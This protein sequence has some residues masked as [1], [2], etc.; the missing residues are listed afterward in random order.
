[1]ICIKIDELTPCLKD[2]LTGE[3]LETEVIRIKR[4]SFLKKFNKKNGWYISWSDEVDK[5]EVYALVLKGTVDIQGLVSIREEKSYRGV[6][7]SWAVAAPHNNIELADEPK[8]SGVGGHLIAI[9]IERS[10]QLGYGG[11]TTGFCK[12]ISTMEHFIKKYNAKS[13]GLIH[14]YQIGFF[15]EVAKNIREVY[16]YEWTEDEI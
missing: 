11:D 12:D 13:L 15:D 2:N 16:T 14:D 5:N 1:M 6:Y 8:Y 9:A 3:I 7:I 10:E 4:K